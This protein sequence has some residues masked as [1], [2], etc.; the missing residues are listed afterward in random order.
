MRSLG[1]RDQNAADQS[2]GVMEDDEHHA[3]ALVVLSSRGHQPQGAKHAAGEVNRG[4]NSAFYAKLSIVASPPRR[5]EAQA[6]TADSSPCRALAARQHLPEPLRLQRR[7][8]PAPPER[9]GTAVTAP[10]AA[11]RHQRPSRQGAHPPHARCCRA[12]LPPRSSCLP[13][14]QASRGGAVPP[15]QAPPAHPAPAFL[16]AANLA[17]VYALILAHVLLGAFSEPLHAPELYAHL[18]V[19]RCGGRCG[20]CQPRQQPSPA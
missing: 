2:H 10:A 19:T 14:A 16:Q 12:A 17:A 9:A 6:P 5:H 8:A 1:A 3:E 18:L 13:P 7:Q 4:A 11:A 15:A 20:A